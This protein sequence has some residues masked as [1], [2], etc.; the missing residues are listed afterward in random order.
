MTFKVS[1]NQ[2]GQPHSSNSWAS[3]FLCCQLAGSV[4]ENAIIECLYCF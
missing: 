3:C 4:H 2:Y 1:D